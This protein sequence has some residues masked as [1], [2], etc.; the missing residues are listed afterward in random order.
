MEGE[1]AFIAV[2]GEKGH[3]RESSNGKQFA[4]WRA[5]CRPRP[6]RRALRCRVAAC[7]P[8]RGQL[9]AL[10]REPLGSEPHL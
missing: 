9:G 1:W 10:D 5:P 3:P 8:L 4:V 6:P 2:L 7:A